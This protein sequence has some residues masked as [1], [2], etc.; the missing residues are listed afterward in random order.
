MNHKLIAIS[1]IFVC[2]VAAFAYWDS[3]FTVFM[4]EKGVEQT[5]ST[6]LQVEASLCAATPDSECCLESE[7]TVLENG[8]MLADAGNCPEGHTS[9]QLR[10]TESLVWC[11]PAI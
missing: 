9:N 7:S 11:E 5:E 3:V 8:Y 10:C 4:P 6:E 2:F 1:L